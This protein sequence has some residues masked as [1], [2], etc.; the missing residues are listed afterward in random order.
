M[1][2]YACVHACKYMSQRQRGGSLEGSHRKHERCTL[3]SQAR[4][5]GS[6]K[7]MLLQKPRTWSALTSLSV[8]PQLSFQP[9]PPLS[10]SPSKSTLVHVLWVGWHCGPWIGPA[11][12]ELPFPS[13]ENAVGHPRGPG[14]FLAS[15]LLHGCRVTE[16]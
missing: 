2:V 15:H 9:S 16:K 8:L 1:G 3:L 14:S 10:S 6:A 7:A 5:Y 11:L 13:G 12:M 4:A